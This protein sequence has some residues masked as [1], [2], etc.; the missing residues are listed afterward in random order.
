MTIHL[1][2][3][4]DNDAI[5]FFVFEIVSGLDKLGF[6]LTLKFGCLTTVILC[7]MSCQEYYFNFSTFL[8]QV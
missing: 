5:C 2:K 4:A 3:T 8:E 7:S 1:W 6:V